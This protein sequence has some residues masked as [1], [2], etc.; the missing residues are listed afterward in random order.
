MT[1]EEILEKQAKEDEKN[2]KFASDKRRR[3]PESQLEKFLIKR[4]KATCA[5]TRA[6]SNKCKASYVSYNNLQKY[7]NLVDSK[8][9]NL[10]SARPFN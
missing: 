9:F 2:A 3:N 7:K 6:V 8:T 10:K 4:M 1:D 5:E